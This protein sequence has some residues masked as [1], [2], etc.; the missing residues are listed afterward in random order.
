MKQL[1]PTLNT[2]ENIFK[3][4]L[5][6]QIVFKNKSKAFK[7]GKL[8]LFKINTFCIDLQLTNNKPYNLV[9]E[10]DIN[11]YNIPIPFN[12]LTQE[13]NSNVILDY[14]LKSIVNN[15]NGLLKS[16]NTITPK[17]KIKFYDSLIEIEKVT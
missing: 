13:S 7:E 17:R 9:K 12:I 6:H 1:P 15:H 11:F 16:L 14:K 2:L 4:L 3:D 8:L 5:Q 10:K